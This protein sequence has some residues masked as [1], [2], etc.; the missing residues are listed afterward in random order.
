[1]NGND[2]W[3]VIV[4]GGNVVLRDQ[5]CAADI[6]IKDGK[7]AAVAPRLEGK[8]GKTIEAAG[9]LVLPGVVDMH[10]HLDEPGLGEWEGFVSGSAALAAGGCTSYA[11]MPLNGL[12]PTVNAEALALKLEAERKSGGSRVDFAL[13]GGLVP[14]NREDLSGLAEAGV[15]GFKAFMSSPGDTG[16]G[17]FRNVDDEELYE[18]MRRIASLGK[19]LAIHAESE[20][21]VSSLTAAKTE[22]GALTMRDY[23]ESRPPDAELEAV[24]TAL[25]LAARSGCSLHVV[26]V[27]APEAI[28]LISEA[29][30]S[31]LD[32]TAETCPHYLVFT[33]EDVVRIGAKAK[34][35]PP[36]RGAREREELWA[37]LAAGE[38]DIIA[39]DHSPC[40]PDLKEVEGGD[41]FRAWGG[42]SCAQSTLEL[43]LSEGWLKRGIPLTVL[44]R[45]MS[46]APAA[47]LGLRGKGLIEAGY[48]ADLAIV[49]PR[50]GY[51]LTAADLKYRHPHSAYEGYVLGCRVA[52]TLLRG[53]TV[54]SRPDNAGVPE[55]EGEKGALGR[56]LIP[57]QAVP[58]AEI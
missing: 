43:I 49:D 54:Y 21:I 36:I 14:G 47:R 53:E 6:G 27:S 45:A 15:V 19:V 17:C 1:M 51:T 4:S 31:G 50:G 44:S 3:D 30:R 13:W 25:E 52:A 57:V 16:E 18:G 33:D 37:L 11:D 22:A 48:D 39:S 12:P 10:V 32:A 41:Y 55:N 28:R 5:V 40:P 24:R 26:H 2:E 58:F 38:I 29:K 23:L 7:I 46:A 8:A 20:A 56:R 42:I 35:S 9:M 34:C